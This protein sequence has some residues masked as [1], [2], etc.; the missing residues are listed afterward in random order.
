MYSK[1]GVRRRRDVLRPGRAGARRGRREH[2][3][4]RQR[5]APARTP[6]A[7]VF[8]PIPSRVDWFA[9]IHKRPVG[10]VARWRSGEGSAAASP[11]ARATVIR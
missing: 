11:A 1:P 2:G 3:H 7:D 10:V 5:R 9:E 4:E 8:I 6:R